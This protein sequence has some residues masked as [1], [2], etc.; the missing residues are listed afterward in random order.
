VVSDAAGLDVR[1]AFVFP[2]T[3]KAPA[4]FA[5]R[6][7]L[8]TGSSRMQRPILLLL[9]GLTLSAPAYGQEPAQ[10]AESPAAAP[11]IA[12]AGIE[13]L[14]ARVQ[15]S[16]VIIRFAG[17]DGAPQ[18][19]GS[20]F[21]IR[22]D[23]L[24][25]TNLHVIGEA[26]PITV[27]LLDGRKF[28]VT[29]VHAHDRGADLALLKIDATG[30]TPLS[31]ALA[32]SLVQGQALVAFGNPQ[33]LKH[34]VVTGVVSALREEIEG[35][36][37]IQLAIP[38][39]QGNSGGPVVDLEGRVHGLLTLKSIVTEN[40]GYAV[41]AQSLQPLID[42]PNPIPMAR[43]LTIGVL[44]PKY[45]Q[46]AD[47]AVRWTQRAGHIRVEGT[48]SEFGGRSLCLS[49]RE[50]PQGPFEVA[51][52]VKMNE[53]DG[54]AGLVFH[55]D[56]G[57]KHYGFY[58]SSGQL[59]FSRFDGP[60]VYAWQ[61]LREA[62]SPHFRPGEWNRIRVR[63]EGGKFQ[64]FCNDEPE[65]EIEDGV[66][67]S[68][69]VGLAKF[70]HTTAEF[71]AFAFGTELPS[72]RVDPAIIAQVTQLVDDI[73]I[74]RPPGA[75]LIDEVEQTGLAGRLALNARAE[76]LERQAQ[77]LHELSRAVHADEIQAAIATAVK[78]A[79]GSDGDL[80]RAALLLA[81][82]DNDELDVDFYVQ[83]VDDLAQEFQAA[84][85]A[86]ISAADK[87]AAFHRFLFEEQG[88]HGARMSYYTASNSYLNEVLDDRE[89]LPITL[90]VVYLELARRVGIEAAGIGLPGHF[91][92]QTTVDGETQLLDVFDRGRAMTAAEAMAQTAARGLDWDEA[93]LQPQ[94]TEQIIIRMLRNLIGL[95][96][97][98]QDPEA[99]LRYTN[100]VLALQP[101][102]VEDRLF[103]AVLCY[104][105]RRATE[106]LVE[107]DWILQH[108]PDGLVIERIEQLREA[109][110]G[111]K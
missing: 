14:T 99:A 32:D 3:I 22:D 31:I 86:D 43:W 62:R 20:G 9:L 13:E 110:E 57:D 34:S 45:W 100:V 42:K 44:N 74:D 93:Y 17:R 27:E 97:G 18:G 87:L 94:T 107:V 49:T 4:A 79:A 58:P 21:V 8:F 12:P 111:L 69:K 88:F 5:H 48:G 98:K 11:A 41:A 108:R 104:N 33:G 29:T 63:V 39:E 95:A 102:S 68:G 40:L 51:V 54:A 25:A 70:R 23:G 78:P 109:L 76:Q 38:I 46:V 36:P 91:V 83:A 10:A 16:V 15:P 52:T 28:P 96:N 73:A 59:R 82:L 47:D 64:C 30:L 65:F 2:A 105:T 101:D 72:D 84:Q 35:Q 55:A 1:H 92:V 80:L 50:V 7:L 89:G 81:A 77:R 56:G 19:I 61:V 71:K 60:N 75:E 103:K 24:I 26:R 90:S 53:D 37:M 67:S 85:P 66:Y 106:G 6:W